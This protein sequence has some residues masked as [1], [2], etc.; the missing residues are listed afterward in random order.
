MP[1]FFIGR[2][3]EPP[4]ESVPAKKAGGETGEKKL[5]GPVALRTYKSSRQRTVHS[6]SPAMPQLELEVPKVAAMVTAAN[7][8]AKLPF[9]AEMDPEALLSTFREKFLAKGSTLTKKGLLDLFL[10]A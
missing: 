2:P 1:M 6:A 4:R 10:G 5:G 3:P 9:F 7:V 8:V